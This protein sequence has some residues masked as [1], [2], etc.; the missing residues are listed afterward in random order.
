MDL[1]VEGEAQ[2]LDLLVEG[3]TQFIAGLMA[4]GLAI[5][6]LRHGEETAQDADDEQRQRRVPQRLFGRGTG[7][8]GHHALRLVDG[9]SQQ[10]WDEKLQRRG[11]EGRDHGD[12]DLPGMAQRHAHDA[13]QGAEALAPGGFRHMGKRFAALRRAAGCIRCQGKYPVQSGH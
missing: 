13:Q 4:D 8:R 6:V 9:A 5:I 10:A 3:E 2:A 11:D 1:V 7:A 12:G